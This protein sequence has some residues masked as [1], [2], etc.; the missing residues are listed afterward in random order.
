[1]MEVTPLVPIGPNPYKHLI[2]LDQIEADKGIRAFSNWLFGA[3]NPDNNWGLEYLMPQWLEE[4]H[5]KYSG[6]C[7]LMGTGPS[8]ASQKA[9][10]SRL[11]GEYTFTC[12]RMALWNDLPFKPFVHCVTEPQPFL[13]WGIRIIPLYDYPGAQNKVACIWWPT[14]VP[15]WLWCPKA[16]EEIQIRWQGFYGLKQKFSPL[17]TGWASPLTIAQLAAWM[18][19]REFY[20]LGIDTTDKGQAWDVE[21]GRTVFPRNTRSILECFE[22]ARIDIQLAGAKVYDC[23]PGGRVNQEGILQYVELGDVVKERHGR[24]FDRDGVEGDTG[25][26]VSTLP[27]KE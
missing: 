2:K 14:S 10:M 17:P 16:P 7:F 12:N 11:V 3:E 8:L 24:L 21:H 13:E 15:G 20:F 6:R 22:R 9:L 26:S 4:T 23:T 1:M 18:G 5:N 27:Q 25:N 19:F